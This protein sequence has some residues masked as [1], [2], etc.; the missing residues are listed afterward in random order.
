MVSTRS[1]RYADRQPPAPQQPARPESA[2]G[3]KTRKG[4][5]AAKPTTEE[6]ED[7]I[8]EEE[9]AIDEEELDNNA[10][11]K[12]KP[13]KKRPTTAPIEGPRQKVVKTGAA[14]PSNRNTTGSGPPLAGATSAE[15][16]PAPKK[17]NG[18]G[19]GKGKGKEKQEVAEAN[20]SA[21]SCCSH[22]SRLVKRNPYADVTRIGSNRQTAHKTMLTERNQRK[23]LQTPEQPL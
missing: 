16:P 19:K 14:G 9:D 15:Q 7:E 17:G 20:V 12:P 22:V 4:A 18:K 1:Q 21:V 11:S 10:A 23:S 13:G 3:G 5:K 8:D 6:D 2:Q